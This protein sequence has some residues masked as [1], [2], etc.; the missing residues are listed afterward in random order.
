MSK[1]EAAGIKMALAAA[2]ASPVAVNTALKGEATVSEKKV[3][4]G[5][6]VASTTAAGGSAG[7]TTAAQQGVDWLQVGLAVAV[8]G[9]ALFIAMHFIRAH[10]ER[11]NAFLAEAAKV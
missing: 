2:G 6:V 7:V 9:I 11:A 8:V 5:T 1:I 10:Q 4:S 3:K